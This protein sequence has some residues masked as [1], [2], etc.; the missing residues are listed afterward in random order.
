MNSGTL[1]SHSA[2]RRAHLLSDALVHAPDDVDQQSVVRV[3]MRTARHGKQSSRSS[4]RPRYQGT[5]IYIRSLISSPGIAKPRQARHQALRSYEERPMTD[6]PGAARRRLAVA[7]SSFATAVVLVVLVATGGA[8]G[9]PSSNSVPAPPTQV[10]PARP[11]V[12]PAMSCSQLLS[13]DFTKVPGAPPA[14]LASA[15]VVG[16]GNAAYCDVFGIA[17]QTV[18]AAAAHQ[19]LPGQIHKPAV[20][21]TGTVSIGVCP[22]RTQPQR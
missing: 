20:A 12:L 7:A 9:S 11:V 6:R 1:R 19:H 17:P 18:R 5:L 13:Q 14:S 15:T 16:S 8:S 4:K 3:D 22:R 10:I 2:R 21:G